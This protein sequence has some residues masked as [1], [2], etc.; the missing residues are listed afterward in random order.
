ML[1]GITPVLLI[2]LLL[3]TGCSRFSIDSKLSKKW[4]L[5]KVDGFEADKNEILGINKIYFNLHPDEKFTANWY[6]QERMTDFKQLSGKW[7]CT[8]G[9][10][11][12]LDLFL[13]YGPYDKETM[14]FTITKLTD[15]EMVMKISEINHYFKA[16]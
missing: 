7:M 4:T 3:F 12:K 6:D 8:Q 5:V 15:N 11:K 2:L 16:K 13:Y 14:V 1:R 9:D 10:D